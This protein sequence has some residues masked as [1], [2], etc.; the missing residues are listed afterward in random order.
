MAATFEFRLITPTGIVYEGP[1]EQAVAIGALG[2][3][4]I[5]AG[6]TD[7]ITALEPG[8]LTL[9][10]AGGGSAEYLLSGGLAEVREGAM[11]ILAPEA[12]PPAAIDTTA[13]ASE[14]P[15]DEERL[16]QMS[17]YDPGYAE[18]EQELKLARARAGIAQLHR[19]SH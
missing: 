8:M 2:E 18:A 7:Y 1:V 9:Y 17:S 16:S 15:S 14:I 3:F 19:V 6:H 12:Q 5:L 13:A 10:L 4:G 11:T